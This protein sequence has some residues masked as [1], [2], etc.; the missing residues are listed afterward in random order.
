ME[1]PIRK[2]LLGFPLEKAVNPGSMA[3]PE[4]LD[5]FLEL[6][7]TLAAKTQTS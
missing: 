3:N 7:K 1:I 5:F 6:A 2:L 4:V